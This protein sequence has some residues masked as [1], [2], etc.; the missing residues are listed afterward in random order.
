MQIYTIH[1]P[2][3]KGFVLET[4]KKASIEFEIL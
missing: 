3:F 4:P 2:E 1:A